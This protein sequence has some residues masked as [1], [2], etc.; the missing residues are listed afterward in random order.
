MPVHNFAL[1]PVTSPCG[2]AVISGTCLLFTVLQRWFS[3]VRAAPRAGLDVAVML[4]WCW[5]QQADLGTVVPLE[6]ADVPLLGLLEGCP[7]VDLV[8]LL[9]T[10][11]GLVWRGAA[12][13]SRVRRVTGVRRMWRPSSDCALSA[14]AGLRQ[15]GF[16][17]RWLEYAPWA[18]VNWDVTSPRF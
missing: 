7:R 3:A 2:C 15:A 9:L 14:W 1:P 18:A 10:V 4:G 12:E 6:Q 11:A 13:G 5:D 8:T 17:Q 16:L